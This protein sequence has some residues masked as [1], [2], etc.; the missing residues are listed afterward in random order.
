MP[1]LDR[2][3]LEKYLSSLLG[4]G[5]RVVAL[6]HLGEDR[7]FGSVKGHGYGIPVLIEAETGGARRR[8]VLETMSAGPFGHEHMP[9]RA[10]MLLWDHQAYNRLPRHVR[11][12]DVAGLAALEPPGTSCGKTATNSETP[13][14][15]SNANARGGLKPGAPNQ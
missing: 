13:T 14:F 8:F 12:L 15:S 5:T 1:D 11:S 6:A 4:E 7:D 9:D 2:A 3:S 10:Q